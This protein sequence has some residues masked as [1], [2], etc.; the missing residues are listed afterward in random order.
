MAAQQHTSKGDMLRSFLNDY[1]ADDL[2][3]I[4]VGDRPNPRVHV[5]VGD[6][7]LFVDHQE[8]ADTLA[9]SPRSTANVMSNVAGETDA[10]RGALPETDV[11]LIDENAIH[12]EP[13]RVADI[14]SKDI[15][16]Y[17]RVS[18]Q[19]AAVTEIQSFPKVTRF[20]CRE[21]GTPASVN[22][23]PRE[24]RE[25]TVPCNCEKAPRWQVD[26]EGTEWEDHRRLKVQQR[27]EEAANGETQHVVAHVTGSAC[28][29]LNGRPLI[30]HV[31][32]DAT[33]YGWVE[34]VQNDGRGSADYLF[35][36]YLDAAAVTF[37]DG[38]AAA[39]D[40]EEHREKVEEHAAADDV[41]E[42]F[43]TSLAPQIHPTDRMELA[44]KLVGAYLFAS[45]RIDSDD[46]PMYRGDIHLAL[47]GDPGMAKSV[48][49]AGAA[50]FSPEAEH[51]SA[52]GLSSDVGLIAAAVEDEF[53]DG[54]WSLRPGILVR[55]GMHA[56]VDEID[57]G[58]DELEKINDA[59]EGKQVATIDKAG[60]KADLKT[61]TGLLVSGNPRDSRFDLN[62]PL[63]QQVDIEAS[64][65]SRFDAIVL[66]IDDPDPEQ[67][68]KVA[69]H[70]TSS[71]ME[72][73]EIAR[74]DGVTDPDGVTDRP[75][76]PEVGRA[77]VTM[78][79]DIVPRITDDSMAKLVDFYVKAREQSDEE[80]ISATA[81]QLESGIRLSMA[82]ARMRLSETVD[83][84]D[85]EMAIN[86]SKAV[87]GQTHN[88]SG[89]FDIDKLYES[90][91]S[92]ETQADRINSVRDLIADL[93]SSDAGADID[94]VLTEAQE[95]LNMTP[96]DVEHEIEK[97]M[98]KG[99]AYE[100]SQGEVRLT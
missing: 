40:V 51:R 13:K 9:S 46:G 34:P 55:A 18:G 92:P 4:A 80:S 98:S 30:E 14:R 33:V 21:C 12:Y 68:R 72:G 91:A 6:L 99:E 81:R 52:T 63:A 100:P 36:H 85:V 23:T 59:L 86:V 56:I 2:A 75:V 20:T 31:G 17:V 32:E 35:D 82:Y 94:A 93:E 84:R 25:P 64:L 41:Y 57:K 96:S 53:G 54:G 47:I 10:A 3:K 58:P 16:D 19:L 69:E 45:P 27:P 44:M 48:L 95:D 76:S 77:W 50:E 88:G 78:G 83:A 1:Y 11:A 24:F 87:I 67:D 28:A 89:G 29:D 70:I 73:V 49:L 26:Y 38:G 62:E 65:L 42:R 60:I 22:Q 43:Y 39:V 79:R 61:R 97:L 15:K 71:Y 74:D 7:G 90:G 66:L 37:E 5:D 8:D